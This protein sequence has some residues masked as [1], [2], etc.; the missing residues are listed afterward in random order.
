MEQENKFERVKDVK[1]EVTKMEWNGIKNRLELQTKKGQLTVKG[2]KEIKEMVKGL[3]IIRQEE[4]T[5]Q[6]LPQEVFDFNRALNEKGVIILDASYTV[7]TTEQ[8]GEEKQYRFASFKEFV[9]WKIADKLEANIEPK[10]E[11]IK[12]SDVVRPN[13]DKEKKYNRFLYAKESLMEKVSLGMLTKEEY[14][15]KLQEL[16]KDFTE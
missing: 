13:T 15:T 5:D 4:M 12:M 7:M 11:E 10:N 9:T 8:D 3:P 14:E 1:I 16:M 2:K 6:D